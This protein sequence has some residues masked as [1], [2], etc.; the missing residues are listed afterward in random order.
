M[1]NKKTKREFFNELLVLVETQEQREFIEKELA[2]LDKKS[3]SRGTTA[4]QKANETYKNLIVEYL[5]TVEKATITEL[6]EN[7]EE[8]SEFSNQ[9]VSSLLTQLVKA[10]SV[11]RIKE[12]K[13]TYFKIKG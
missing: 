10:E 1:A 2:L 7:I 13:A 6:Q 5:K 9:K 11:E 3:A 4:N 12:K 8:I